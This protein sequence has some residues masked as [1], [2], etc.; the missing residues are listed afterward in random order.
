MNNRKTEIETEQTTQKDK[1]AKRRNY[2]KELEAAVKENKELKEQILRI[3]AEFD[4]Y[5]KRTEREKTNLVDYANVELLTSLLPVLDDFSRSMETNIEKGDKETLVEGIKLVYKS[6]LKILQNQGLKP[7][8]SEGQKFN[9]EIHDALL[10]IEVDGKETDT[11]IEEHVKGYLF[12]DRVIRHAKVV[13][14][15]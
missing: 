14:A 12:K 6:F 2:K 5:R 15:K 1:P 9:P 10:Q 11:I 13:V 4:N 8:E 3:A 7:M